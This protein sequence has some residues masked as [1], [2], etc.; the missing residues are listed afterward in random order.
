MK[1]ITLEEL[2]RRKDIL[3]DKL[4]KAQEEAKKNELTG[5]F[6]VNIAQSHLFEV[7]YL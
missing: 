2:E 5:N 1:Y 3:H 6:D 4:K 7:E